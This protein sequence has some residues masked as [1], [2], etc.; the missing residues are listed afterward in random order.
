MAALPFLDPE[1]YAL[2]AISDNPLYGYDP[3]Y[4]IPVGGSDWMEG[5]RNERRL[6]NALL[7][8]CGEEVLY[9][10]VGS[11]TT[12]RKIE[13]TDMIVVLDHYRLWWSGCKEPISLY[14]NMYESG[15]VQAPLGFTYRTL[16]R[17]PAGGDAD[18]Q[19]QRLRR[20][21]WGFL[22]DPDDF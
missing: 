20:D 1:T 7:G 11:F 4:P 3:L 9:E 8:P 6:L 22:E 21:E 16:S 17:Y 14:F 19:Q 5:P 2:S 15:S 10:R 13:G 12:D 18:L